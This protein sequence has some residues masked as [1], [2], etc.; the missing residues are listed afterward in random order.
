MDAFKVDQAA[1]KALP[2]WKQKNLKRTSK[3]F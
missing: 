3:L 2:G 1:Y